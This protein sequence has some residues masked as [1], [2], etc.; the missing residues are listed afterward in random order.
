MPLKRLRFMVAAPWMVVLLSAA[1]VD[2]RGEECTK[3]AECTDYAT[4]HEGKCTADHGRVEPGGACVLDAECKGKSRCDP[5][6]KSCWPAPFSSA[7]SKFYAPMANGETGARLLIEEALLLNSVLA[8][9]QRADEKSRLSCYDRIVAPVAMD[10]KSNA[11]TRWKKSVSISKWKDTED[12]TVSGKSKNKII[13][14]AGRSVQPQLVVRCKENVLD[15]FIDLSLPPRPEYGAMETAKVDVRYD[16]NVP[17]SRVMNISTSG[18]ALF[19]EDAEGTLEEMLS[20]K[21][22]LF[23]F[24]PVMSSPETVE[25][26]LTGLADGVRPVLVRC[27]YLK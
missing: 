5:T 24:L 25:F 20:A 11:N 6:K 2:G 16:A 21:A 23:G 12:V 4:C 10:R 14:W 3:A 22:L 27:G 17:E 13:A 18:D 15:V 7:F 8:C 19:F 1:E 9:G 26:D